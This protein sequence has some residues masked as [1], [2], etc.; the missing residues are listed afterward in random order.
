MFSRRTSAR[1]LGGLRLGRRLHRASQG[2]PSPPPERPRC[3]SRRRPRSSPAHQR[4]VVKR[5]QQ[6]AAVHQEDVQVVVELG[7]AGGLGLRARARRR[8]AGTGTRRGRRAASMCHGT[9]RRRS[10]RSTP[11]VKRSASA[12]MRS[13]ASGEHLLERR[14]GRRRARA[15]CRP[16]CRRRRR[17]PRVGLGRAHD[18][19]RRRLGHPVGRRRDAAGD[20]LADRD[21]S[22]SRPSAAVIRPGRRSACGSRRSRAACRCARV[23][24]R[25]ASWKPG[26]GRTMPMLVSA[27]SARTQATSSAERLLERRRRR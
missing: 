2:A 22:G 27:G 8:R 20:R 21:R 18:P 10:S 4:H 7:V 17:R 24:S 1:P 6:H 23:S 25:S 26:S 19:R 14:A 11:A 9:P 16:A 13:C 15:R 12:I 3:D 5:R